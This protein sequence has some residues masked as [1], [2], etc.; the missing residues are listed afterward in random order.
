[1]INRTPST[2]VSKSLM[3]PTV[4]V[5]KDVDFDPTA[6]GAWI[7]GSIKDNCEN[8]NTFIFLQFFLS[9]KLFSLISL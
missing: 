2:I 6:K 3:R 4:D 5:K 9:L 8:F 7:K 1:M